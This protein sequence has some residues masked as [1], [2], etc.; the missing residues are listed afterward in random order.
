MRGYFVRPLLVF[1]MSQIPITPARV[2]EWRMNNDN[3]FVMFYAS[4]SYYVLKKNK[5]IKTKVPINPCTIM[6]YNYSQLLVFVMQNHPFFYWKWCRVLFSD[7]HFFQIVKMR[8]R[9][10]LNHFY[11]KRNGITFFYRKRVCS[12]MYP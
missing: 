8:S 4:K 7:W 6:L 1:S 10:I 3:S 9:T 12:E 2:K 11:K 5:I